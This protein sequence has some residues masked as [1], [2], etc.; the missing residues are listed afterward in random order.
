M[1]GCACGAMPSHSAAAGLC[2][3]ARGRPPYVVAGLS[4]L[5]V[6]GYGMRAI[7]RAIHAA[8]ASM[9]APTTSHAM[10]S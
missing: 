1:R 3:H 7:V 8:V 6:Y 10:R 4:V 5:G 9:I 2:T